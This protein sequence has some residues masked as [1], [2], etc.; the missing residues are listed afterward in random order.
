M[1]RDRPGWCVQ[2]KYWLIVVVTWR[3]NAWLIQE[4]Y[5]FLYLLY[6]HLNIFLSSFIFIFFSFTLRINGIMVFVFG[7]VLDFNL[8]GFQC[9]SSG[10]GGFAYVRFIFLIYWFSLLILFILHCWF[11]FFFFLACYSFLFTP[12]THFSSTHFFL[13]TYH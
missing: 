2:S 8:S 12:L 10:F 13:T 5:L 7:F 1:T 9:Y 3:W 11:Y 6:N 4:E